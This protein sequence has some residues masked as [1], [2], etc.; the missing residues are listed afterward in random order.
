MINNFCKGLHLISYH[1]ITVH[2]KIIVRLKCEKELV[3]DG[4]AFE[5]YQNEFEYEIL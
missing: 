1:R 5:I 4:R 3:H 2:K